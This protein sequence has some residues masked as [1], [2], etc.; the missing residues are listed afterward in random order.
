MA[1]E[2]ESYLIELYTNRDDLYESDKVLASNYSGSLY[3]AYFGSIMLGD[4]GGYKL[5]GKIIP[6]EDFNVVASFGR[7]GG[8]FK[9][10]EK[11]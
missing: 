7:T 8:C 4:F 3:F 10:L 6:P 1:H 2:N 9:I 5:N 11:V